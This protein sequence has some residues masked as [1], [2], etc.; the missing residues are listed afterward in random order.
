MSDGGSIETGHDL[1]NSLL[2]IDKISNAEEL[3]IVNNAACLV[4]RFIQGVYLIQDTCQNMILPINMSEKELIELSE[5]TNHRCL[6]LPDEGVELNQAISIYQ[7]WARNN[8]EKLYDT[9]R[10]CLFLSYLEAYGLE[11]PTKKHIETSHYK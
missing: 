1:Y 11:I 6:N 7:K 5:L 2:L 10:M 9:A 4:G 8:P 3:S